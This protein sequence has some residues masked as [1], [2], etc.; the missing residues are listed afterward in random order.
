MWHQEQRDK[1]IALLQFRML[2]LEQFAFLRFIL[3]QQFND[4]KKII[5]KKEFVDWKQ[6]LNER[7]QEYMKF[8]N[9]VS[10][11]FGGYL[12]A[13]QKKLDQQYE[14]EDKKRNE[15]YKRERKAIENSQMSE[16]KKE[17]MLEALDK[18]YIAEKEKLDIE[19]DNKKR[20]LVRKQAMLDKAQNIASAVMNVATGITKAYAAGPIIGLVLGSL[21]AALGAVQIAT[22]M[23]TPLPMSEG[24]AT[25]SAEGLAYL[26]PNEVVMPLEKVSN[27]FNTES[28][29]GS[30]MTF[31]VQLIDASDFEQI[32]RDRII[33][34][35]ERASMDEQ[36]RIDQRSVVQNV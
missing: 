23:R 27:I 12:Q 25:G 19:Y 3:E 15:N 10:N 34:I 13:K 2:N 5:E 6:R 36:F 31:N 7:L 16:A 8:F 30:S 20:E 18:K 28:G 33:P 17:A 4:K 24:G 22:I 35:I 29:G 11:A 21:I 26:H 1:L 9:L 32:T 14:N